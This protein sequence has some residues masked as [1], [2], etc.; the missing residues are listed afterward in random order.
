MLAATNADLRKLRSRCR[1]ERG[2]VLEGVSDL[3]HVLQL[4]KG[5]ITPHI[6]ISANLFYSVG[7]AEKGIG[8]LSKCLQSDPDSKA[9]S[10]LRKQEKRFEKSLKK[11]EQ[12][13]GKRQLNSAARIL[14]GEGEDQGLLAE[15]KEQFEE[16]KADG[17]VHKNA[18][19]GLYNRLVEKACELY[20]DMNNKKRAGEHCTE[21]LSF[22]PDCLP[23][24]L[25][26][27]QTQIDSDDF[28]PAIVT[29]NQ[30]K[31]H[32]GNSNK[33]NELLQKAH[34]LLKRSKSK[35]YY[36]VLG[37]SRDA[38]DRTIKK[39]YR[40][41]VKQFHPDKAV[42][43]GITKEEAEK[44]IVGLNE[45]YEVL[46]DPEKKAQFDNGQD[47]ND[48]SGGNPFQGSPFGQ[49]GQPIFFQSGGN[50]FGGGGGFKFHFQG[51]M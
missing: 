2:E 27:A 32:H 8:Q 11:M 13:E 16:L 21:A 14:V 10:K 17:T 41:L 22:N 40:S 43:Q 7:D 24:L 36:K 47:P 3:Q 12:L 38:D 30:A 35:D 25:H 29:L 44:K 1:F 15:A 20:V 28:E 33:I 9:C 39:A 37:V 26:K 48:Q 42:S 18:P 34:N 23:G 46:S 5:D 4:R 45:A 19:S 31:E 51:G 50:P 49:G 6:Q